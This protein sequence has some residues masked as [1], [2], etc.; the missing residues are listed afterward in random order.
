MKKII[1]GQT[2]LLIEK[3]VLINTKACISVTCICHAQR[4]SPVAPSNHPGPGVNFIFLTKRIG[5]PIGK[6]RRRKRVI[7]IPMESMKDSYPVEQSYQTA[8]TPPFTT[9]PSN[10]V[11]NMVPLI[12][13][14]WELFLTLD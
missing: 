3:F 4:A 10:S 2:K 8:P 12:P 11:K 13:P 9:L 5:T 6:M 1:S 14:Q 7:P